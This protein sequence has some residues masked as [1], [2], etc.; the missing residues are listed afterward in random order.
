MEESKWKTKQN[1]WICIVCLM[2]ILIYII[3]LYNT[4]VVREKCI[5]QYDQY[6]TRNCFCSNTQTHEPTQM[7]ELQ[8]YDNQNENNTKNS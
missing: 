5:E 1:K 8:N 6:I 2:S 3:T 7:I 4:G